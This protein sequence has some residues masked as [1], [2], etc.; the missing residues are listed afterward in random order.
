MK[1]TT[2]LALL[3]S[4][5]SLAPFAVS[6][7]TLEQSYIENAK[8]GPGVPVPVSVVSPEVSSYDIGQVV[9]VEFV[10]EATG[11]TSN[12][13][14]KSASDRDFATAVVDAVKQWK[15]TPALQ[16]G[17]PVATKV[18]LPVR[19]VEAAKSE[20]RLALN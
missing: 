3:L 4:L 5:G 9:Q 18:I 19:V 1:N 20:N 16:N 7:K 12:I 2:K 13:V 15:F 10:V 17:T 11:S 14:I 8:K 6:A